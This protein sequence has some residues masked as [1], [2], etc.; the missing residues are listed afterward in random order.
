MQD[1]IDLVQHQEFDNLHAL[2]QA[3][4]WLAFFN[5]N[6]AGNPGGLFMTAMPIDALHTLENG[7]FVYGKRAFQLY[8]EALCKS[9]H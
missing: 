3:P 7:I 8:S 1:V 2:F 6:F 4:H 5:L 9:Y